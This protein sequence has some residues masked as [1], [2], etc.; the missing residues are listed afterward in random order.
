AQLPETHLGDPDS[1]A[2]RTKSGYAMRRCQR[3]FLLVLNEWRNA[4]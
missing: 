2:R 3:E 4:P 1:T